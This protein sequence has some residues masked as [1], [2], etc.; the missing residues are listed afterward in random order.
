MR[1]LTGDLRLELTARAA[2]EGS[3]SCKRRKGKRRGGRELATPEKGYQIWQMAER[4]EKTRSGKC[5]AGNTYGNA[6]SVTVS[7]GIL[8]KMIFLK[9]S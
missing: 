4:K 5:A 2:G 6:K 9:I 1:I 8:I 3:R 7:T